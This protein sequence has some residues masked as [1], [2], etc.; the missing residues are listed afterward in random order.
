MSDTSKT[1]DLNL[2]V[3]STGADKIG[4]LAQDLRGVGAAAA[5]ST[6]ELDRMVAEVAQL[7]AST[8]ERR[9]AETAARAEVQAQRR[10]LDEQREALARLRLST[11]TAGR[12]TDDYRSKVR[13]LQLGILDSRS[14]LRQKQD[15]L[16]SAATASKAAANAET[17]LRAKLEATTSAYRQQVAAATAS[18]DAQR[19]ATAAGRDGASATSGAVDGITGAFGRLGVAAGAALSGREFIETITAA[20]SLQRGLTAVTGSTEAAGQ[21]MAW[22]R[23][24][25]NELGVE[26]MSAGRAYLNLTAATQGTA[27][28]G[29]ATREVFVSVA[30]AM[31]ALGKSSADTEGALLAVG[32][33]ASKGVV[34]M[35]ELR[36]QLG[37]RLPG[38]MKAAADGAGVTVKELVDMVE[39]GQVLAKDLLPQLARGLDTLYANGSPPD[40]LNANWNRLKNSITE[41]AVALGEGG[42]GT[43]LSKAA[44]AAGVALVGAQEAI[45]NV[46]RDIGEFAGA[47]ATGN[48]QLGTQAERIAESES[49]LRSLAETAGLVA[50]A[51]EA[52]GTAAAA[53]GETAAEA[54]RRLERESTAAQTAAERLGVGAVDLAGKFDTLCAKGEDV[55]GA[56]AKIGKD[57]DLSSVAGITQAEAA[58]TS[59]ANSGRISAE[60][61]G[62]AWSNALRNTDLQA[63]QRTAAEAFA[64]TAGEARKMGVAL[65]AIADQSLRRVGS[66]AEEALSGFSKQARQALGDVDTLD[67]S[68]AR[69]GVTGERASDLLSQSLGNALKTASTEAAVQAVIDRLQALGEAG[70]ISGDALVAGLDKAKAKLDDMRDGVGSLDEALRAFGMATQ[71]QMQA[72]ADKL[73][74]AYQRIANDSSVSLSQQR[75]A[76]EQWA[77]AAIEANGGIETEAVKVARAILEIRI[78][79]EDAGDGINVQA[80]RMRSDLQ[81]V[82]SAARAAASALS[83]IGTGV[84]DRVSTTGNTREERLAGQNAVDNSWLFN[85]RSRR[86]RGQLTEQDLAIAQVALGAERGN[87][88]SMEAS[89]AK[90]NVSLH[91]VR[92]QEGSVRLISQVIADLSEKYGNN[93]STDAGTTGDSTSNASS[94]TRTVKIDIGGRSTEINVASQADSNALVSLLRQ[95]ESARGVSA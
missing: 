95:L 72:T 69:L 2:R 41:V 3:Q 68:L 88:Y 53:A 78:A 7:A 43:G 37:E 8:E 35:E 20:E 87:L 64:G 83:G 42:V 5:A 65:D 89:V 21:E 29:E 27:L 67:A 18:A 30:R 73:G 82:E 86:D 59:L 16:T 66:S 90:G 17:D 4:D 34:S 50:P 9:R 23:R 22:L 1:V 62:E 55:A 13:A 76:F 12:A 56:L 6:P 74:D 80:G 31:S 75:A 11:D 14:A 44:G 54:F 15:A 25:S 46:G 92:Q 38:A 63:F 32:Q 61:F 84:A 49:K 60:Q 58:L 40:T 10:A 81:G 93:R 57:I 52:I 91:A 85:L 36:Q 28:Q 71:A 48:F 94:N 33:M 26:L 47:V 45:V 79:A 77:R 51:T 39:S 19:R 24:T 70:R